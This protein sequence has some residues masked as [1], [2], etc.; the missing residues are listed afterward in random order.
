[1]HRGDC[2]GLDVVNGVCAVGEWVAEK[3]SGDAAAMLQGPGR[4]VERRR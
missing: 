3:F 4:Y 2:I 1:M